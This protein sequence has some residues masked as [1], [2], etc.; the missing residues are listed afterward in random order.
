MP[1]S[2]VHLLMARK[3]KPNGSILFYL[4][5]IAPDAVLDWKD[6]D[7]THFRNLNDRSEAM[8]ALA[9]QIPQSD[10]F[11]EG[12]L[13]HLFT[14]WRWDT[15]ARDEFIKK[16]EGDWFTRYRE[17]LALSGKYAFCHSDWAQDVWKQIEQCD[18][19]EYNKIPGA[20]AADLK[21]FISHNYKWH[22][23]NNTEPSAVFTPEYIE[24]FII[25]IADEYIQWK[26]NQF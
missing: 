21:N 20:T 7:I 6:K 18:I 16:N 8:A 14:D 10:E 12:I 9:L 24:E 15:L 11:S 22:C 5:C 19:S 1:G 3:V 13:L 25:K 23:E 17:E 4:G 2:T 26:R